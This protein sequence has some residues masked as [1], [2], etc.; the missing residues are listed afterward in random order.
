M[1]YFCGPECATK[2]AWRTHRQYCGLLAKMSDETHPI[3]RSEVDL[4][5]KMRFFVD[6]HEADIFNV[7]AQ[8]CGGFAPT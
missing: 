8:V 5:K 2:K 1:V 7:G 3:P 6:F 4:V